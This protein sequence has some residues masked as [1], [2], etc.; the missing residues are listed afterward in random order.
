ML[1]TAYTEYVKVANN[2]TDL[3]ELGVEGVEGDPFEKCPVCAEVERPALSE[4]TRLVDFRCMH[5]SCLRPPSFI[6]TWL[7]GKS[8][9]SPWRMSCNLLVFLLL[10]QASPCLRYALTPPPTP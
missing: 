3:A 10:I 5:L 6:H 2:S 7:P 8:V 1:F 4:G 9:T